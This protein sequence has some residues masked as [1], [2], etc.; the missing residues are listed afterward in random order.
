M[1]RLIVAITGASG[2]IYGVR[3]LEAV[4]RASGWSTDLVLSPSALITILQELD[5]PRSSANGW[6]RPA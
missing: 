4:G 1:K 6:T 2:A 3:L 5:L